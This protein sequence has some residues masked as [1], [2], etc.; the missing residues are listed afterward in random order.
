MAKKSESMITKQLSPMTLVYVFLICVGL[1]LAILF[2]NR[3]NMSFDSRS[4]AAGTPASNSLLGNGTPMPTLD[5]KSACKTE[6]QS[7]IKSTD[8]DRWSTVC[9]APYQSCLRNCSK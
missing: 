3:T 7:C 4:R 1:I 8:K 5:C 2:T 9:N 6:Y